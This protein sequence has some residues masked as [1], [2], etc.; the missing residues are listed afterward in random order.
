VL[1]FAATDRRE[2][3][4]QVF[5]DAEAAGVWVNVADDPELC[6]FHLPARVQRGKLQLAVASGGDAPFV[7]RRLRQLLEQRLGPEWGEWAEA[8]GRFRREVHGLELSAAEQEERFDRFF[9]QTIDPMRLRARVPVAAEEQSWLGASEVRE[10]AATGRQT[11]E[12][13]RQPAFGPGQGSVA[14]VGAG[15]GCAGLLTLRGRQRLMEADAVVYDRLAAAALPCDLPDQVELH[16]VGKTAGHHPVPQQEI[17]ALLVRLARAGRRVVRLKGG[18]PYVFGRGS[19]EAE[20]LAEQGIDFEVVPGVTSGVAAPGWMGV[21]V[22]H[23]KE[24]VRLTLLT[25]HESV[26]REGAQVRWDLLARDEHATLVGYMGLTALPRVVEKLLAAGMDPQMPAAVVQQGTMA[27]Q[28]AVVSTLK[29]L[30]DQ[31]ERAG[32]A[33]PA[34]F[35]IGPTVKHAERLNW[36]RLL[37]L[38]GQ[39]L[40]VPHAHRRLVSALEQ[41]G[42]EVVAVPLPVSPAARVVMGAASL[43]GCV[44]RSPAEVEALDEERSGPGWEGRVVAWCQG[45]ATA[46]RAEACGWRWVEP[47]ADRLDSRAVVARIENLLST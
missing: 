8:A 45:E 16:P 36:Y 22:T 43:T 46:R 42:A 11:A 41:A 5:E 9:E 3:N 19:E 18:D 32:L 39:R 23:R 37:P 31:V 40:V 30:P 29:G 12:R 13:S 33:P 4:R 47:L 1:V 7:V 20:T 35:V 44:V 28:R 25:A 2:V 34:L 24:S 6:S 14:L 17:N 15:P 26:K 38:A 27:A 10:P 21:P